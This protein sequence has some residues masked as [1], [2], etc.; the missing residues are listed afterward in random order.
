M[1][2]VRDVPFA[3]VALEEHWFGTCSKIISTGS[4]SAVGALSGKTTAAAI[5]STGG[6][7]LSDGALAGGYTCVSTQAVILDRLAFPIAQAHY[8]AAVV[9]SFLIS[10]AGST[11]VDRKTGLGVYLQHGD[12]SGGGDLAEYSTASRVDDRLYF[13]TTKRTSDMLSW[14]YGDR[15]TGQLYAVSHPAYYDLRN[16]KRYLRVVTR[17]GK[18][19]VTTDTS[20]EEGSR[21]GAL[22]TFLAADQ[23]PVNADTTSLYSSTTTT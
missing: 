1:S 8:E 5:I 22:I 14:D 4:T 11:E 19:S 20:G 6:I 2:L 10:T 23:L 21:V 12:S 7:S 9:Q 15:S 17:V 16:A 3:M 18:N 13:G